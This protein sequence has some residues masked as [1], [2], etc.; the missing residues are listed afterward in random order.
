M[1]SNEAIRS[2]IAGR[3][4][5]SAKD[6]QVCFRLAR[7]LSISRTTLDEWEGGGLW[8]KRIG[9]RKWYRWEATWKFFIER[10]DRVMRLGKSTN[11]SV[12]LRQSPTQ[13]PHP[14]NQKGPSDG[15]QI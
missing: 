6:I 4:F 2:Y 10:A 14:R 5:L 1:N 13:E 11:K 9:G 8:V 15:I 12:R 7:G 3:L